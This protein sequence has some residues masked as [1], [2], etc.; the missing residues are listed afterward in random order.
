LSAFTSSTR[1]GML[2]RLLTT[3]DDVRIPSWANL[4]DGPPRSTQ[5]VPIISN[6][7]GTVPGKPPW[8]DAPTANA[9]TMAR[10]AA[11]PA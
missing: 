5:S 4:P 11:I 10:A 3:A 7:P 8:L 6:S 9:M 1:H 2:R